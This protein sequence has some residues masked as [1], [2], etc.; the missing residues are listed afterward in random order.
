MLAEQEIP[1]DL[2]RRVAVGL[3]TVRGDLA[4]EQKG[5]LKRQDPGFAGAIVSA[6]Q[7]VALLV[8]E[9][10]VVV[11]VKVE[12][13]AAN[14]LPTRALRSRQGRRGFKIG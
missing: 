13:A 10:L 4:V 8:T 1:F 11:P 6:Q 9:L 3:Q 5:E 7:Q 14:R 2:L 12:Q